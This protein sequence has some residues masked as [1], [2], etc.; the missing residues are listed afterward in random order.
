MS[1]HVC[2]GFCSNE[3]P[4]IWLN[5]LA[6]LLY[7]KLLPLFGPRNADCIID[8]LCEPT[9]QAS[10]LEELNIAQWMQSLAA[11]TGSVCRKYSSSFEVLGILQ[12]VI[13]QLKDGRRYFDF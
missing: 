11:F 5:A 8:N 2:N 13:N 9:R 3:D 1:S 6:I 12:Y 4:I 10:K 7:F